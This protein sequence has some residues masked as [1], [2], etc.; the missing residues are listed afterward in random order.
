MKIKKIYLGLT[1]GCVLFGYLNITE[2]EASEK[3]TNKI[4]NY[5]G[6]NESVIASV[7]SQMNKVGNYIGADESVITSVNSQMNKISDYYYANNLD[8]KIINGYRA[9]RMNNRITNLGN[10]ELIAGDVENITLSDTNSEYIGENVFT[11]NSDQA[12]VYSTTAYAHSFSNTATTT[13]T[14]GFS[15]GGKDPILKIPLLLPNGISLTPN[16]NTSTTEA[17]QTSETQ[18]YTVPPQNVN[19]PANKKYM[20]KVRFGKQL[21][22]GK[23]KF[24]GRSSNVSSDLAVYMTW[25]GAGGRPSKTRVFNYDTKE[26]WDSL[27]TSEQNT[28]D[29]INF[30]SKNEFTIEGEADLNGIVGTK[31]YVDTYDITDKS[32]KVLINERAYK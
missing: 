10:F 24:S 27:S 23:I 30:N 16:I 32:N 31:L 17:K 1:I 25:Q 20:V 9:V 26:M 14:N 18:T 5:I 11:N 13:V 29:N 4:G 19:V 6:D 22:K 7:N 12:Q 3:T 15:V 8:W 28:I 21:L 2:T